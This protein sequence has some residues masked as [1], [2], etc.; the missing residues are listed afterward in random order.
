VERSKQSTNYLFVAAA[1]ARLSLRISLNHF[2]V[3]RENV[4]V[5]AGLLREGGREGVARCHR[6][7]AKLRSELGESSDENSQENDVML[8][9][10][11]K[12]VTPNSSPG[13]KHPGTGFCKERTRW[14]SPQ[15]F[16]RRPPPPPPLPSQAKRGRRREVEKG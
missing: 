11:R 14:M 8:L 16:Y 7:L 3:I 12:K 10:D 2:L 13:N 15:F 4:D 1:S 9:T 6:G 5:N